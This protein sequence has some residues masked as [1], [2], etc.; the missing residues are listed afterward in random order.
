MANEEHLKIILQGVEVWNHWRLD[1]QEI[2]P[3]LS[4]ANLRG[5]NLLRV[6]FS[7]TILS[8]TILSNA[9]LHY[10]NLSNTDLREAILKD[11]DYDFIKMNEADLS[12]ANLSELNLINAELVGANLNG[13]DLSGVI[14]TGLSLKN[15]GFRRVNLSKVNLKKRNFSEIDFSGANL[16]R[17]NLNEADLSGANLSGANLSETILW[18]AK[19]NRAILNE[20]NLKK[21]DLNEADLSRAEFNRADLTAASLTA[22]RLIN[23]NLDGANLTDAHL[24]ETQRAGWSIKG[25]ICESIYWDN[26]AKEK[27]YYQPGDFE[28]LYGEQNRIKLFYKDGANLLEIATLPSIIKNLEEKHPGCKLSFQSIEETSGGAIATLVLEESKDIAVEEVE[29][30]RATIQAEAERNIE[31]FRHALVSK[32]KDIAQLQGEVRALDRTINSMMSK[33]QP[34]IYINQGQVEAMGDGAHAHGNISNQIV[35]A[36]NSSVETQVQ[37][38][39]N[40]AIDGNVSDGNISTSDE[41]NN[42]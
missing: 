39:R 13:A 11:K 3:D 19:L 29:A 38:D 23:A 2:T 21:T 35:N 10:S 36:E 12:G 14:L 41:N 16:S 5:K 32:D 20:A 27:T 30:I 17:A 9:N 34:V 37:G 28:R 4:G 6:N 22:A 26:E 1:N 25:I 31:A 40:I 18:G 42:E 24:W 15:V 7:K 8:K 33:L